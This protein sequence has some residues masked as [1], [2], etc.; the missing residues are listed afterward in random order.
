VNLNDARDP[1]SES[2]LADV[3]YYLMPGRRYFFS[4]QRS[5]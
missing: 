1:V 5:F 4:V 2:E 3:Q